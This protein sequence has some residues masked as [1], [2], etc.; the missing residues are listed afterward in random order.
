MKGR[1][2]QGLEQTPLAD[3]CIYRRASRMLPPSTQTRQG[4]STSPARR[5]CLFPELGLSPWELMC[6]DISAPLHPSWGI[7]MLQMHSVL[8][9]L[10]GSLTCLSQVLKTTWFSGQSNAICLFLLSCAYPE[11]LI[12]SPCS[13]GEGELMQYS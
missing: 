3:I 5:E 1:A 4:F 10:S 8:P 12:I 11:L 2:Q 7:G 6:S 13:R 9:L